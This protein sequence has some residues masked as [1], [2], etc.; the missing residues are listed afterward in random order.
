[1]S[2]TTPASSL[3]GTGANN[4]AI[5]I[6]AM[7][8]IVGAVL[9]GAYYLNSRHDSESVRQQAQ[10]HTQLI[11]QQLSLFGESLQKL[12]MRRDAESALGVRTQAA[13]S[14]WAE[15][16]HKYLP[17]AAT[18]MLIPN[19][20]S[21]HVVSVPQDCNPADGLPQSVSRDAPVR[22]FSNDPERFRGLIPVVSRV[23]NKIIGAV[24]ASFSVDVLHG[25]IARV[26]APGQR[27]TIRDGSGRV[28]AAAGDIPR[29]VELLAATADLTIGDWRLQLQQAVSDHIADYLVLGGAI[30]LIVLVPVVFAALN[31]RLLRAAA[32][33]LASLADYLR[34]AGQEGFAPNPPTCRIWETA[35]LLPVVQRAF[36]GLHRSREALEELSFT[37]GLTKLPNRSYFM[38]MLSHAFELARRGTDICLLSLEI[39]GFKQAND[40][41][42]SEAADELL[43]MVAET[44]KHQ[45]RKSDFAGRL[46]VYNFAAIFYNAK[47][48]LMRNRLAQLQQ[49]FVKRQKQSAATAGAVYCKLTC[50]LTYVDRHRDER[51]DDTLL[52]ADNALRA[53]KRVGGNHM[54]LLLPEPP[55]GTDEQEVAAVAA[56]PHGARTTSG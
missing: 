46:G 21:P 41:L 54:E 2:K 35:G 44:L 36:A 33:E 8:V 32:S 6:G 31:A 52:R 49:D 16:Q 3:A 19:V 37:D 27:A 43:K 29:E 39:S 15:Q 50:G 56:N 12:S 45:T 53:A 26:L 24:C 28:L 25:T 9:W 20:E 51:P 38:K 10:Q 14:Q 13:L 17:Q 30:A 7:I 34:M 47:G 22:W 5:N 1:V 11:A 18:L 48:H 23:D 40:M 42:G 55:E 4:L